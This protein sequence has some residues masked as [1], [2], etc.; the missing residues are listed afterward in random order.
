MNTEVINVLLIENNPVQALIFQQML[1]RAKTGAFNFSY[2]P[3]L[4]AAVNF[5]AV[6]TCDIILTDLFL[7]DSQGLNTLSQL[8]TV[9]PELPILILTALNDEKLALEAVKKGAQDYL[10]KDKITQDSLI[11]CLKYA[12]ERHRFTAIIEEKNYLLKQ[13]NQK[14]QDQNQELILVNQKLADL[15]NNLAKEVKEK[16]INLQTALNHCKQFEQTL[17]KLVEGTAGVIGE[18]FFAA[19]VVNLTEVLG[20]RYGIVA[21]LTDYQLSSIAFSDHGKI[22]TNFSHIFQDT[23]CGKSMELGQYYCVS[24]LN[25]FFPEHTQLVSLKVESYFGIA[26]K[27]SNNQVIG[28]LCI[29]DE[30]PI[31]NI[32]KNEGIM[33]IFA[34]RAAAEIERR[35]AKDKLQKLNK[36]LEIRVE[37]RTKEL[38]KSQE[39]LRLTIENTPLGIVTTTAKGQ[40][41]SVNSAFCQILGYSKQELLKMAIWQ[42][43]HPSDQE[44]SWQKIKELIDNQREQFTLE[45]RYLHKYGQIIYAIVRVGCIRDKQNKPIQFVA[46]VEDV[47]ERKRKDEKLNTYLKD[48]SDFKY[49]LDEATIVTI[50]DING[51]ITY[52]NNKFCQISEYHCYE[53]MG[54]NHRILNSGYHNRQIFADLWE[55]ITKGEIWRGEL[56]NKT[57]NGNFYWIDNTIVPFLNEQNKPIQYLSISTD[58]TSRKQIEE[59]L[60]KSNKLLEQQLAAIES[61]NDG[62]AI[63]DLQGDY[64]YINQAY[65]SLFGY[66]KPEELLGKTWHIFYDDHEIKRFQNEVFPLFYQEKK[67]RG[68]AIAKRKDGANFTEEISLTLIENIG[69]VCV[70]QDISDRKKN[71]ENIM[72]SLAKEKELNQLKSRFVAMT[73]HE[74]RTPLSII[75][76][77]AAILEL[78]GDRLEQQKKDKHLKRIQITVNNMTQLLEDVLTINNSEAQKIAFNPL[79]LDLITFC[80]QLLEDLEASFINHSLIYHI[81]PQDK[82]FVYLDQ[83]LM[84]QILTNLLSNAIKYSPVGSKIYFTVNQEKDMINFAIQDEGIGIPVEDQVRLFESFHRGHNVG[85]IQGTGLGLAIV[86][87]GVELHQGQITFSSKIGKGTTFTV[88]IPLKYPYIN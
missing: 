45:K 76:S 87:K 53:V 25:H 42:I 35:K 9:K 2:V 54:K 14:L 84:R 3:N 37:N 40:L 49:A 58:I 88:Q 36:E 73:S 50:T 75:S 18:D 13:A 1:K 81:N 86:K 28:N 11:R 20:V 74:F 85:N 17:E 29:L 63:L 43:T 39:L 67:W 30:K 65:L 19:L 33:K 34:T 82:F 23:P 16:T 69:I 79:K 31:K 10:I 80:N 44:K 26:L 60:Y 77:S 70:C 47:T 57:K 38:E 56:K 61:A 41:K 62:I 55:T 15:T 78:Y 8:E 66:E 21:E 68:E 27:D 5:L 51:N 4:K 7:A 48:L 46:T 32:D 6:E 52:A 64:I 83:K 12:I 71:E 59:A 72:K 24:D 22:Q